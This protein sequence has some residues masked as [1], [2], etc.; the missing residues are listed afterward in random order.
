ML[1]NL[2]H[3]LKMATSP[4]FDRVCINAG[5]RIWHFGIYK[6]EKNVYNAHKIR[7][8]AFRGKRGLKNEN[9]CQRPSALVNGRWQEI[10]MRKVSVWDTYELVKKDAI[11]IKFLRG[12]NRLVGRS[13][14]NDEYGVSA[15]TNFPLYKNESAKLFYGGNRA[16]YEEYGGTKH[17]SFDKLDNYLC[18]SPKILSGNNNQMSRMMCIIIMLNIIVFLIWQYATIM[19]NNDAVLFAFMYKYFTLGDIDS[20]KKDYMWLSLILSNFSHMGAAHILFNMLAAASFG[21][22]ILA[23]L[24]S[25][26]RF[27]LFY[28]VS[29]LFTTVTSAAYKELKRRNN[30]MPKNSL[31]ASGV[32]MGMITIFALT[33]PHSHISILG[34]ISLPSYA[35]VSAI[36]LLS[37]WQSTNVST[38]SGLVDVAGHLGGA[39][40]GFIFWAASK[41]HIRSNGDIS[42]FIREISHLTNNKKFTKKNRRKITKR[43]RFSLTLPPVSLP[44]Y[45]PSQRPLVR[46]NSY[47]DAFKNRDLS[48]LLLLQKKKYTPL[49]SYTYQTLF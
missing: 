49:A 7:L 43:T 8:D 2:V 9:F 22:V 29:C 45:F 15:K 12:L 1:K 3:N 25:A 47:L 26:R 14:P 40:G 31:G 28:L 41:R 36:L 44:K 32:V 46:S 19:R 39:L 33:N 27:V 48:I 17:I 20:L 23:Y 34:I 21:E 16:L 38:D 13:S 24:G 37:I 6:R 42:D 5:A 10:D 4:G 18:E 11:M 30:V 35:F